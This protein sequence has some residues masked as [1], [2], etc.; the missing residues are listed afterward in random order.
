MSRV[1]QHRV[2]L[3]LDDAEVATLEGFATSWGC[4]VS[5]AL[6]RLVREGVRTPEPL[7]K[8]VEPVRTPVV[9]TPSVRTPRRQ[10]GDEALA[11]LGITPPPPGT[12][13]GNPFAEF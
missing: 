9:G 8:I 6:R 11:E 4:S 12:H 5:D 13:L 2:D 7:P 3:R 10:T 1:R